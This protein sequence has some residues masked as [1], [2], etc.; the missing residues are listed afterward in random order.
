MAGHHCQNGN[1]PLC[2]REIG[3]TKKNIRGWYGGRG[4]SGNGF[5]LDFLGKSLDAE[6]SMRTEPSASG[7]P[8]HRND[9]SSA[10]REEDK[11]T[12]RPSCVAGDKP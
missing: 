1:K 5:P 8:K 10:P 9:A 6:R 12:L 2:Q 3:Q 4:R 7:S 11:S